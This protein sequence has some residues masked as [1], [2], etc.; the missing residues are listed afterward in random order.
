[1][2]QTLAALETVVTMLDSLNIGCCIFDRNNRTVRWNKAMLDLFPE[3]DGHLHVGEHY[4]EN[5]LRFYTHRLTKEEMPLIEEYI[6]AGVERHDTQQRPYTFQHRGVWLKVASKPLPD[7]GRMR[8]WTRIASANAEDETAAQHTAHDQPG[9]IFEVPRGQLFDAQPVPDEQLLEYA[10]DGMMVVD[11]RGRT[12]SANTQ[13]LEMYNLQ[14]KNAALGLSLEDVFRHVWAGREHKE[15]R[16]YEFGLNAFAENLRFTGSPFLL[17]LPE[18][19]WIRVLEQRDRNGTGHFSHVDITAIKR[20]QLV[21]EEA[22]RF[23]SRFLAT[24]SHDL[25]QPVHALG[26]MVEMLDPDLPPEDLGAR[27]ASVRSCVS[28]LSDMLNELLDLSSFDLG[29]HRVLLTTV[30]MSWLLREASD[31]FAEDCAR[32]GLALV[33]DDGGLC[34]RSDKHLL[35][36]IVFNLVSNAVKYTA[37]GRVAIT[38]RADGDQVSVTVS[39]TGIGIPPARLGKVFDDYIRLKPTQ[40]LNEGLGI[41]LTVVRLAAD[42][43]GHTIHIE[44][45]PATGTTFVLTMPGCSCQGVIDADRGEL[46][47]SRLVEPALPCILLVEDDSYALSSMAELLASWGYAVL[48]C[49]NPDEAFDSVASRGRSPD[50]IISDMHL[51]ENVNGLALI[52]ELRALQPMRKLP[53]ILLTGDVSTQLSDEAMAAD[54]RILFKPLR[55]SAL[56]DLIASKLNWVPPSTATPVR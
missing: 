13:F 8:I 18:G 21:S 55:P 29:I 51:N 36:R 15:F 42:L 50:L 23:K 19:R 33:V 48:E 49:Q 7:G 6:D 32:K 47:R 41:G 40:E 22:I 28:T 53:A 46:A 16:H 17:P 45:V 3:H 26:M 43:L 37:H 39:D 25:R 52:A 10:A 2:P 27:L 54:V 24:A 12:T 14:S 11:M 38:C 34:V 30:S 31:M 20:Q 56:R 1:M 4:R 9:A 35:R 5:L 44:S